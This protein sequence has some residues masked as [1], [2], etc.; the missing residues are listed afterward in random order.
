[1][2][3][4]HC[5]G[6]NPE[7]MTYCIRCGRNFQPVRPSGTRAASPTPPTKP[8]IPG[9]T[10][11]PPAPPRTTVQQRPSPQPPQTPH[12]TIATRNPAQPTSSPDA[13]EPPVPFPPRT[14]AQLQALEQGALQYT[15]ISDDESYGKKKIVRIQFRRCAPWQQV[16][17]LNKALKEYDS[18]SYNTVIIQGMYNQERN[19]YAYNNGQLVFDRNVR[20]GGAIQ[21]RYQ[22]ETDDGFSVASL[23]FV[24]S[25]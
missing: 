25:E 6:L 13:P 15:F 5:G 7:N 2:R 12:S 21:N 17:T 18:A 19:G 9:P 23:R 24:L 4:P 20:L 22:F 16:A 10:Y 1:M 14:T 8:F 11:Q 3:C